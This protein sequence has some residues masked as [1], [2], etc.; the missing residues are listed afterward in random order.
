VNIAKLPELAR[1]RP[2]PDRGN[3]QSDRFTQPPKSSDDWFTPK[4]SG[5]IPLLG[6]PDWTLFCR[7]DAPQ[8]SS[9]EQQYGL[10]QTQLLD[11]WNKN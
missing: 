3:N 5:E 6:R 1:K 7:H 11:A 8:K 4:C 9:R 10:K 2:S